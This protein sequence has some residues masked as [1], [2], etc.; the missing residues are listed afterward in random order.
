V[1][2]AVEEAAH[3]CFHLVSEMIEPVTKGAFP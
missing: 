3:L 1:A 2:A